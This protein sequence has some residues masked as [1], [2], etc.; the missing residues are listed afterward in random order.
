MN[1]H[2]KNIILLLFMLLNACANIGTPSGGDKDEQ[3]PVVK[4][5]QPE[6]GELGFEGQKLSVKFDEI[7]VLKNLNESFLVSPPT[8]RKPLVKAYG[9]ELFVEFEEALQPNTTYTLYFGNAVVDNNEGNPINDFTFSFSTGYDLDTMRIQGYVLD[10]QTLLPEAGIIVGIYSDYADSSFTNS[11]PLRIAKTDAMGYFSIKNVSPGSYIA[12]AL[13]EMDNDFRFNQPG[14]KIAFSDIKLSP[15]QETITLLDSIFTDSIGEND[16]H[17][18]I[19][20]EMRERDTIVYYP[21]SIVL[22]AFTEYHP[23]QRLKDRERKQENRLDYGFISKITE[24]PKIRLLHDEERTDWYIPEYS[25]DSLMISYWLKDT[26]LIK[27]DTIDVI[28]DYQITDSLEQYVWQTDTLPMRFKRKTLSARQQRRQEREQDKNPQKEKLK[29]LSLRFNVSSK[30]NYFDDIVMSVPH[31]LLMI[32]E[33]AIK[34]YEMINDTTF[35]QLKFQ[36]EKDKKAARTYRLAYA[37]NQEKK[38]RL[39]IDS[40][41]IY[42]IYGATNDAVNMNFSI[43]SED[44]FSS[45]FLN[46]ENLRSKAIV[47]L[48]AP[49]QEVLQQQ[50]VAQDGEVGF[51]HLKPGKYYFSLFYDSNDNGRWDAGSYEEKR[52]AEE[53]RFFPKVIETKAYYEMEEDWDVENLHILKQ[54][55]KALK[56][57]KK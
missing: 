32:N 14:E 54:R 3:A 24:N 15:S 23:F 7:V 10:A 21:D 51:Y 22:M 29:P 31:P 20:L 37:W 9:K 11:I 44:Q 27:A 42:D 16:E 53:M 49:S 48:L 41:S 57:P 18:P 28:F 38:Y 43:V 17:Y 34:L 13:S 52:Q 47:Q 39:A 6:L 4:E 19:F 56:A 35:E 8:F 2:L 40:A 25:T 33:E 55:P 50:S 5:S 30:V 26:T 36:W 46:I 12:R 1:I 45:I